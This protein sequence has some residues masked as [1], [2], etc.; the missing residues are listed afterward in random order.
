VGSNLRYQLGFELHQLDDD[1][2]TPRVATI[3]RWD[4]INSKTPQAISV[5]LINGSEVSRAFYSE[6]RNIDLL[7]QRT[8]E[9]AAAD[10]ADGVIALSN[11]A[12]R[13]KVKELTGI[14][15]PAWCIRSECGAPVPLGADRCAAGDSV[16]QV[17]G[18]SISGL[19]W[20]GRIN[21]GEEK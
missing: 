4:C 19:R 15:H 17:G 20:F 5:I 14:E 7:A 9:L 10:Q 8:A 18:G 21:G 13:A 12:A 3:Q 2:G 1:A 11:D 16:G 6:Q